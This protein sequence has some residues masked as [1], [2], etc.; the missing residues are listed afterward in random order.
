MQVRVNP[1]HTR[2]GEFK[3][4]GSCRPSET[5]HLKEKRRNTPRLVCARKKRKVFR[6]RGRNKGLRGGGKGKCVS[7]TVFRRENKVTVTVVLLTQLP[8]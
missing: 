3:P 6:V 4:G 8:Y 1:V 5:G 2:N 7:V